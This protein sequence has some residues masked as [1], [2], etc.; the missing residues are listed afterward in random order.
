MRCEGA[1]EGVGEG[2][3]AGAGEGQGEFSVPSHLEC[4]KPPVSLEFSGVIW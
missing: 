1:G 2:E 4:Q 3:G